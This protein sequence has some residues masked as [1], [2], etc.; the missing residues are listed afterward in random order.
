MA[1]IMSQATTRGKDVVAAVAK[2]KIGRAFRSQPGLLKR[3]LE[4]LR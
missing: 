2:D 4:Q 1:E 3:V